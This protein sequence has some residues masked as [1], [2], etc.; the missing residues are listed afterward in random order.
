[1]DIGA[2]VDT[3]ALRAC[4]R[5]RGVVLI[6]LNPKALVYLK[7][8][9]KFLEYLFLTKFRVTFPAYES[10]V[11]LSNNVFPETSS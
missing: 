4:K 6:E 9:I 11:I 2:Y 8:S 5:V 10:V 7:A 1:M 3:Y